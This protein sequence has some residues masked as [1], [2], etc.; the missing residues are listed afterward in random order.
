MLLCAA[1]LSSSAQTNQDN[2]RKAYA[3][4]ERVWNESRETKYYA[5]GWLPLELAPYAPDL[6]LKLAA[7]KDG[8]VSDF[9]LAS[10]VSIH[11]E[12][13]GK[14]S[15]KWAADKIERIK[16]PHQRV[17]AATFLGLA[18]A[19]SNPALAKELLSKAKAGLSGAKPASEWLP[20]GFSFAA[21]ASLAAR[22]KDRS[23]VELMNKAISLTKG[24]SGGKEQP[25]AGELLGFYA[26]VLAKGSPE[27]AQA[28]LKTLDP[29]RHVHATPRCLQPICL[30]DP[31]AARKMLAA[32]GHD[33]QPDSS[34]EYGQAGCYVIDAIGKTDASA[35][36]KIA[37]TVTGERHRSMA[38]ALAAKYQPIDAAA[39]LYKEAIRSLPEGMDHSD[40]MAR[41][42]AIAYEYD[43]RTGTALFADARNALD[44]KEGVEGFAFYYARVDP[45]ECKRIL[46]AELE[47]DHASPNA[48]N[49][50]SKPLRIAL[51]MA[52]ADIDR[53]LEIAKTVPGDSKFDAQRKIAQYILAPEGV[54]RSIYFSRWCASDT[55]IPGTPTGW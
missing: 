46:E 29:T 7:E 38:L 39:K 44:K 21:L 14:T 42:A 19:E 52:A 5:R 8:S 30:Y 47:D 6:T 9:T 54:R 16:G 13:N 32:F 49:P 51:A 45:A 34:P 22:V 35:A 12:T 3:V 11:S 33:E 2:I 41:I 20:E 36:L 26:E 24:Q 43:K 15:D 31:Q 1:A 23:A 55:W 17:Y 27:L 53:A 10:A 40:T 25:D 48:N 28:M 4:L 50:H 18:V 37:R